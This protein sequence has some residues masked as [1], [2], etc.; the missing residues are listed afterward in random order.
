MSAERVL[1][2]ETAR[3]AIDSMRGTIDGQ[4]STDIDAIIREGET[5]SHPD[6]WDGALARQFRDGWPTT[7]TQLRSARDELARLNSEVSRIR[8][9]IMRAGGNGG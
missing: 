5:L 4:L 1:A 3:I 9:D 6:V 7:A 2:T 8:A